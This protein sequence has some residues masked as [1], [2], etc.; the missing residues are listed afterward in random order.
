MDTETSR[1]WEKLKRKRNVQMQTEGEEELRS[2]NK[3]SAFSFRQKLH[4]SLFRTHQSVF[5]FQH[6]GLKAL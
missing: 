2:Q 4:P 3:S 6:I 1:H 5:A